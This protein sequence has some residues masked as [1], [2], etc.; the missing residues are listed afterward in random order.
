LSK[1]KDFKHALWSE[2]YGMCPIGIRAVRYNV[3]Q[4]L[5][6]V[7]LQFQLSMLTVRSLAGFC[8]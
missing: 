7:Q 6:N 5:M 3:S 2:K 4:P 8:S 1:L